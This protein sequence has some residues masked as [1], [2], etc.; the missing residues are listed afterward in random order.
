MSSLV[1][2][3]GFGVSL[4]QFPCLCFSPSLVNK[5]PLN[6]GCNCHDY[7]Y[8]ILMS[9][10]KWFTCTISLNSHGRPSGKHYY[11]SFASEEVICSNHTDRKMEA[12]AYKPAMRLPV[13]PSAPLQ[14]LPFR[15]SFLGLR[16]SHSLQDGLRPSIF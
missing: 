3:L 12:L 7:C 16:I 6:T 5:H 15:L 2:I 9:H 8:P 10:V 14:L 11:S 13:A 1:V 4:P